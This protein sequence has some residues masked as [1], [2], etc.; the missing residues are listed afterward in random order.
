MS[1]PDTEARIER[2]ESELRTL[3]TLVTALQ[4]RVSEL[5]TS[6]AHQSGSLQLYL[7]FNKVQAFVMCR[8]RITDASREYPEFVVKW[9][10]KAAA[11]V[12]RGI[13]CGSGQW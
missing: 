1:T 2:L 4:G 11:D 7:V 6:S 8:D 10:G 12:Q 3:Q 9:L 13:V 5:S